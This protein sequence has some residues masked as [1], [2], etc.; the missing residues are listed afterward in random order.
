M[1][2][3]VNVDRTTTLLM[4]PDLRDWVKA[5]DVVH[6]VIEAVEQMDFAQVRVNERGT[7]SEQF[8]PSMLLALLIYSYA[9]G[10]YS[11]RR[12][13]QA[14]YTHV[15][16]RYLSGDTH[17]DHDTIATFRRT[18]LGL[19]K[20]AFSE[21]LQLARQLGVLRVGTVFL[22]GTK[23]KANA[24]R[25]AN[26]RE[27][28]LRAELA[29]IDAEVAARMKA[30][31]A[32]DRT[33]VAE[34]LPE[35]LADPKTRK[36]KLEAA[37]AAL[38]QRAAE[39]HRPPHDNDLGNTTDPDSRRQR[40]SQGGIQGYN[41]QIAATA[42]GLI[43]AAHVCSDNQDRRQL[44][45]TLQQVSANAAAPHTVVAD[46]GYDSHEQITQIENTFNATVYIPPQMP[47][48]VHTRQ[49][50]ADARRSAERAQRRERVRTPL[51]QQLMRQR[52][53]TVE[54][55]FGIIKSAR[56]F[57]RFLLRGL[58]AVDAEWSLLCTAFNLRRLHRLMA[59]PA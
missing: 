53:S 31:E 51:G 18:N 3:F 30:A 20:Q 19:L 16:V 58:A 15:G 35:G 59:K 7:G 8:P 49:S 5:D 29:A 11:S 33:E 23:I 22:D 54:P 41:A 34:Q 4:P 38:R 10:I 46:T 14:T 32:A 2:R 9:Q 55:I 40:T 44:T 25:R 21:V 48:E 36:A 52:R 57:S 56:G 50:R 39:Q 26:R 24:S 43:V 42:D 1:A 45:P 37:R 17:P 47:V 12:I 6:L 28:D 13:E 27:A